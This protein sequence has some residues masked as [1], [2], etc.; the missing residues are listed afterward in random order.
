M[1]SRSFVLEFYVVEFLQDLVDMLSGFCKSELV[2]CLN[3]A[4]LSFCVVWLLWVWVCVLSSLCKCD[5]VCCQ[6]LVNLGWYVVNL[7][8]Y[9]I[10]GWYIVVV[11]LWLM[12]KRWCGVLNSAC[13]TGWI[14]EDPDIPGFGDK[15][16]V[17]CFKIACEDLLSVLALQPYGVCTTWVGKGNGILCSV[18]LL[19]RF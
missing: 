11:W 6:V 3:H 19:H 12:K 4:S 9:V 15:P 10:L 8:W 1:L 2:C 18:S 5:W 13:L 14:V 17:V 16:S 7:S